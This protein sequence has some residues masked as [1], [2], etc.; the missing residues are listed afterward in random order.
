[1]WYTYATTLPPEQLISLSGC[2]G[3]HTQGRHIWR[4]LKPSRPVTVLQPVWHSAP[5]RPGSLPPR[6]QSKS[7]PNF[8]L[9]LH[10][11]ESANRRTPLLL[12]CA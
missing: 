11:R 5:H 1:M 2:S 7:L 12:A 6:T 3:G 9:R 4:E 8:I 10:A